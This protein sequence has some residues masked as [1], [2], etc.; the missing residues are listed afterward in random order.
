[1]GFSVWT[2]GFSVR[3]MEFLLRIMG[4]SGR[5]SHWVFSQDYRVFNLRTHRVFSENPWGFFEDHIVF[6]EDP[7]VIR[8]NHRVFSKSH[9]V[10]IKNHWVFSEDTGGFGTDLFSFSL[11]PNLY[12]RICKLFLKGIF[13]RSL[14]PQWLERL[15]HL[16]VKL[17]L[18]GKIRQIKTRYDSFSLALES[19][20][21][22]S[23]FLV[24][25]CLLRIFLRFHFIRLDFSDYSLFFY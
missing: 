16:K 10:F 11:P 20:P 9:R 8:E 7:M 2:S 3:T 13:F 23:L 5:T 15:Q 14:F 17:G 21:M 25:H 6:S 24:I 22:F 1:M 12:F 4:F 19:I 18:S